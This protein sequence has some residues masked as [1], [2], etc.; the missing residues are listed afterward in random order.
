MRRTR[1]S[2][3]M[4]ERPKVNRPVSRA[5]QKVCPGRSGDVQTIPKD[6][7]PTVCRRIGSDR[8]Q[9]LEKVLQKDHGPGWIYRRAAAVM[10]G[11]GEQAQYGSAHRRRLSRPRAS[12]IPRQKQLAR[13]TR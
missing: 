9:S 4:S 3:E 13:W 11:V 7:V 10:P 12:T 5:E 8:I 6:L 1:V 2:D